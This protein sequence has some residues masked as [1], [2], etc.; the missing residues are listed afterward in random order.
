MQAITR[1]EI[2]RSFPV[3]EEATFMQ[4][5]MKCGLEEPLVRRIL[6]HAMTKNIFREPRKGIVAHTA[7]SR[8]LAEDAQ[9]HDWVG[10][11]T[12]ELWQ[13]ASQTV[14]ALT[15]YPRSQ[16]PNQTGFALANGTDKSIYDVFAQ[17]P[18]RAKRFGNVMAAYT[19]GTGYELEHL[20]KGFDWKALGSGKVVDVRP[21]LHT[22]TRTHRKGS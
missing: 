4:I 14:N 22:V 9:I 3:H 2:A 19:S 13:G 12:D 16:E 5:S 6:R 21:F 15:M 7:A 10:A 18:D 17:N 20:V 1:F 8:L 11:S